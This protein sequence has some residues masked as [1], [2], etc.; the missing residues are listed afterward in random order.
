MAQSVESRALRK[1]NLVFKKG[2]DP[3]N[4]VTL[5]YSNELLTSDEKSKARQKTLTD[6]EKTEEVFTFLERRV[7]VDARVFHELLKVLQEEPAL[8][9]VADQMQG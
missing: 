7:S 6:G 1:S 2:V 4:L 3:D 5:L 9:G 8:K